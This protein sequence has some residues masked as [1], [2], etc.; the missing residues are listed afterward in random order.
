MSGQGVGL[1]RKAGR[2]PGQADRR[3]CT[4]RRARPYNQ[5]PTEAEALVSRSTLPRAVA[6]A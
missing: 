4:T 3:S 2:Q 5:T 6:T 1:H